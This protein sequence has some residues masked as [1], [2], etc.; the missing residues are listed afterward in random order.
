MEANR[1]VDVANAINL[2]DA[3]AWG[4][5]YNYG[6]LFWNQLVFGFVPAQWVGEDV[7]RALQF[8]LFDDSL[9]TRYDKPNGSC[10]SG[11][12]EA[13]MA[14]GYFGCGLFFLLG[15]AFR[16]LWERSVR[17]SVMCQLVLM[18]NILPGILSFSA[19]L[20]SMVNG[21]VSLFVFA[22]PFLWWSWAGRRT[23]G[24][25]REGKEQYPIVAEAAR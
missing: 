1:Y 24:K 3:K 14:F 25:L 2:I 11:I 20:W 16:W 10:D 8:N 22:G 15:A 6:L 17:G 12:A 21:L 18:L 5:H 4:G 19:Q 23:G 13:F 9:L 7:K